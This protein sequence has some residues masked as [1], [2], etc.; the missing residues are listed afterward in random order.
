YDYNDYWWPSGSTNIAYWSSYGTFTPSTWATFR[1]GGYGGGSSI[2]TDPLFLS[3][4]NLRHLNGALNSGLNLISQV[5]NDIDGV[6]RT[7]PITIGAAEY[8]PIALDASVSA[9]LSNPPC[10]GPSNVQVSVF[11]GGTTTL[12]SATVNWSVNG[13]TQTPFS[14]T[15]SLTQGITSAPVTV[16]TFNFVLGTSYTIAAWTTSPNGGTDGNTSND[17][18]SITTTSALGGTY[19][20]GS[21]GNFATFT[22]AITALQSYGVCSPTVF[23]IIN[24]SYAETLI[25]PQITGA[26][27]INTITF[28]SQSGDSTLVSLIGT[29]TYVLYLNGADYIRLRKMTIQNGG[30]GRVI[31]F[32]NSAQYNRIENCRIIGFNTTTNSTAYSLIY[33]G[34]TA[35]NEVGTEIRNNVLQYGNAGVYWVGFTS[36]PYDAGIIIE[37]NRITDQN[38]YGIYIQYTKGLIIRNN[39]ID[40]TSNASATQYGLYTQY[41]YDNTRIIANDVR[42]KTYGGYF[43]YTYGSAPLR[44]MI[45]NNFFNV[46]HP[47][48]TTLYG[49]YDYYGQYLDYYHNTV[50]TTNP[51]NIYTSY[52]LNDNYGSYKTFYNNIFRNN[53]VA[54]AN[55]YV[56]YVFTGTSNIY[57][58]ND[59]WWPT[60]TTNLAYWSSYGTFNTSQWFT[61]RSS[62]YGGGNSV[63]IDPQFLSNTNLRHYTTSLNAGINLISQVGTD[64]DGATRT[65]PVTIG[66]AEYK[67]VVNDASVSAIV[68]NPPCIGVSNVQISLSNFGTAALTSANINWSING[69]SQT[70]FSWTGSLNQFAV[71][72]PVTIGTFNFVQGS[73]YTIV[74]TSSLPNGLTDGNTTNDQSAITTT[75]GLGGTFTIGAGGNYASFGAAVAALQTSG[76]CGPVV[77]R[78]INGIYT[79]TVTIP[80]ISGANSINTITFESQSGDSTLVNLQG[81]ST[82]VL[83]LNGADYIRIRKMTLQNTG[84]GRVIDFGNTAQFNRIENCRIIGFNTTV[85]STTYA[86]IYKGSTTTSESGTEIRNNVLQYGNAGVYWSG[87][88]SSPYEPGMIIENNRIVDNSAYG[89]F[90]QYMNGA[91]VRSNSIDLTANASTNQYGVYGQYLYNSTRILSNDVRVKN[92]PAFFQYIYGTVSQRA[93]VANNFFTANNP[94]G[95]TLY[96]I[97]DY[98]SN[99]VDYLHNSVTT[100]N[101]SSAFTSYTLYDNYGSFKNYTN[102]IFR[103]NGAA[104]SNNYVAYVFTGTGNI[105]DYNDYWWPTGSTNIAYWSSFGNFSTSQWFTFRSSSYGGG[106]SINVDPQFLSSTNLR[107]YNVSL[108]AGSNLLALVNRDIDGVT[109]TTPITI[110]AAEFKPVA[111]DAAISSINNLP[112]CPGVGNVSVSISNYGTATL[113]SATI[114]WSINGVSQTPFSWT[115]SL[116]QNGTP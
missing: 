65:S 25:I 36:L 51:S 102:N 24:G 2:N 58:Y 110:G 75:P 101:P 39:L 53:G 12:T 46:N 41:I 10:S 44:A 100:T 115:G 67:P 31:D 83:Y 4:V 77:F 72:T 97:Y 76:V 50:T 68:N 13:V 79:E 43:Y 90:L 48:G 91:V 34:S 114:N 49:I 71:A 66:A 16:G 78:V 45:A 62:S 29:S 87:Y 89:V 70:P 96:G 94:T 57:D 17:L 28:Q 5:S 104:G 116:P 52:T 81:T 22:A 63:N 98:G 6:T 74:A 40:L 86:L 7:T 107:H 42:A 108:N 60:G 95:G 56:A 73:N 61:F 111:N 14:W 112:P 21:G 1:S 19:T 20:I 15:G 55:N 54:G 92:Y 18:S 47:T 106:N 32:G 59:Y 80:Q 33:K 27:S 85:N 3:S 26:N 84:T 30:A 37:N 38:S 82:Y 103:N 9:I 8:K 64:I 109:R 93:L 11:S 35:T 23:N 69:V 105:F 113:T 88:S 99:Y